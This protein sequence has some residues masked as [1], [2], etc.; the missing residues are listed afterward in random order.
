MSDDF[1]PQQMSGMLVM[2]ILMV[3]LLRGCVDPQHSYR[4]NSCMVGSSKQ[5]ALF[6][7]VFYYLWV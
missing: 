5:A 4:Y 6:K 2:F 7:A 1:T 3:S